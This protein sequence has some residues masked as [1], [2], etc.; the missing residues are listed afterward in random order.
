MVVLN[1]KRLL[2]LPKIDPEHRSPGQNDE[3][4]REGKK[5]GRD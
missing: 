1:Y 3:S 2:K 5:W 4:Q